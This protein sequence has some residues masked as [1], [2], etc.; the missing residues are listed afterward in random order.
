MLMSSLCD[1]SDICILF[2]VTITITGVEEEEMHKRDKH[3]DKRTKE[4]KK[5]C[6]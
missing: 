1:Y 6:S 2:K 5:L 3:Q 4:I